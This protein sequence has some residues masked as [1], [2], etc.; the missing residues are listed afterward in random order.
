MIINIKANHLPG[1]CRLPKTQKDIVQ[2]EHQILE[3]V[4]S[5]QNYQIFKQYINPI[6]ESISTHRIFTTT[7]GFIAFSKWGKT[8][9][10]V[11]DDSVKINQVRSFEHT[12]LL[13]RS[14]DESSYQIEEYIIRT[15]NSNKKEKSACIITKKQNEML[16]SEYYGVFEN[17]QTPMVTITTTE[18]YADGTK[19]VRNK[20]TNLEQ[21]GQVSLPEEK[22]IKK[23]VK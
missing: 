1:K 18:V 14:L 21:I 16:L 19:K 9:V 4:G 12:S 15:I 7:D 13:L 11:K 5:D 2:L 3:M 22:L 17:N 20:T 10:V 8:S 6:L 23:L